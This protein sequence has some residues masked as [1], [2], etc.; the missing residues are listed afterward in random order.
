MTKSLRYTLVGDGTSDRALLP[1]LR[2]TLLRTGTPLPLDASWADP[3]RIAAGGGGLAARLQS[4]LDLYPCDLLFVHRDAEKQE[5]EA[6]R[7]EIQAAL[8]S[9]NAAPPA[10]C[11]V[12]VRMTEAWLLSD[13]TAIRRAADNPNGSVSLSLPSVRELE[14][15]PDP[16]QRLNELLRVACDLHGRRLDQFKRDES[17][18]RVR[19]A[20]LIQD[21]APLLSLPA[22]GQLQTETRSLLLER[23]WLEEAGPRPD[24]PLD[25]VP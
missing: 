7:E 20:D 23:G 22:F 11:V 10:L 6:R 15:L 12:P 14:R 24:A 19:V 3:R 2:W 16:K 5:P 18:R 21:F 17:T 8:S 9:L 13:E 4:A 25:H 1:L